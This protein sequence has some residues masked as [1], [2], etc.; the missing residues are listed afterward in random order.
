MKCPA[1]NGTGRDESAPRVDPRIVI[2]CL[3]CK[4]EGV[5]RPPRKP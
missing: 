4:G 3:K 5:V 1:C 2:Y